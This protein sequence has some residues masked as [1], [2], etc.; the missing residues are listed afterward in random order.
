MYF[1]LAADAVL[2]FHLAFILFAIFGG[3]F[4][5]RWRWA[6]ALHLPAVAWAVFVELTGRICPLT[7]LEDSL[8]LRAGQSGYMGDFVQ[9]YLISF[10]YPSGLTRQIQFVLA[11]AVVV[12]N[13]VIYVWIVLRWRTRAGT[14]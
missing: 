3:V 6:P 5:A 9:H 4:A 2:L 7:Y 10:I 12:I 11:A 13:I 8:R 14:V 1:H